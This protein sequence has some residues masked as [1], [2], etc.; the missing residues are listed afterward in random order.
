MTEAKEWLVQWLRDAHAVEE[1]AETMMNGLLSR[2]EN[3]PVLAE[4]IQQ[5]VEET[6]D[7]LRVLINA[8][9]F[10]ASSSALKDAGGKMMAMAQSLSGYLQATKY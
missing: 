10:S 3:Y 1:Q 4:R 7:K 6:K 5:H 9:R 2:I 8:L